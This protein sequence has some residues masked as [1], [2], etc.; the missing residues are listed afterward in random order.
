VVLSSA[1]G[2]CFLKKMRKSGYIR[3][4]DGAGDFATAKDD[5]EYPP[6]EGTPPLKTLD[7]KIEKR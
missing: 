2:E 6:P 3:Y 1:L 4:E 7:P 5:L